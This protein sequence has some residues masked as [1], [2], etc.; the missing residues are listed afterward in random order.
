MHPEDSIHK[1]KTFINEL[2]KVQDSYFNQL[3]DE[4][5]FNKLG[6]DYLFDYIF[7]CDDP[8]VDDF[9]HYLSDFKRIYSEM[10]D[11]DVLKLDEFKTEN[12]NLDV[13]YSGEFYDPSEQISYEI[14]S[15]D[16]T[17]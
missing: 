2:Q 5:N 4:L 16:T 3:L 7:N 11:K 6:Q 17:K 9:S 12:T 15:H 8:Y 13:E 10:I 14:L 1:V